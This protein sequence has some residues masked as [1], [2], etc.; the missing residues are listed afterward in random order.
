MKNLVPIQAFEFVARTCS[1]CCNTIHTCR[2]MPRSQ[3]WLLSPSFPSK[4]S[5]EEEDE[6]DEEDG[7]CGYSRIY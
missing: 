7:Q 6:E 1:A 3:S 4:I 5:V 2:P